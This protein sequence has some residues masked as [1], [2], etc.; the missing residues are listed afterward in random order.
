M[1]LTCLL[2][3]RMVDNTS[4]NQENW[5]NT[6][7]TGYVRFSA[8]NGSQA[9]LNRS[10]TDSDISNQTSM[11]EDEGEGGEIDDL[12]FISRSGR[13]SSEIPCDGTLYLHVDIIPVRSAYDDVVVEGNKVAC[14]YELTGNGDAGNATSDLRNMETLSGTESETMSLDVIKQGEQFSKGTTLTAPE[15]NGTYMYG[16]IFDSFFG[17]GSSAVSHRWDATEH[18]NA[19]WRDHGIIYPET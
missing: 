2:A 4:N 14:R 11:L 8:P 7:I 19:T 5:N 6:E 18:Y 12:V 9:S 13:H 16:I 15:T 10:T 17:P 3:V 1:K